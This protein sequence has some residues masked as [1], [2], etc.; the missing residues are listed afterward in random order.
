MNFP[1]GMSISHRFQSFDEG[2][3]G[4]VDVLWAS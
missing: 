1:P 2:I 3:Y 4:Y